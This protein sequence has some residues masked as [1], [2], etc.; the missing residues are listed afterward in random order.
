MIL[1]DTNKMKNLKID[2]AFGEMLFQLRSV[3]LLTCVMHHTKSRQN[4]EKREMVNWFTMVL[5]DVVIRLQDNW[6]QL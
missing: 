5:F 3:I 4:S 2:L 1:L 6:V